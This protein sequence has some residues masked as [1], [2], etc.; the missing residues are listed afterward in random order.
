M[1][2]S[3]VISMCF[4]TACAAGTSDGNPQGS[5][6][7]ELEEKCQILFAFDDAVDD[8]KIINDEAGYFAVKKPDTPVVILDREGT[9]L[10]QTDFVELGEKRGNY[11]PGF[12]GKMWWLLNNMS[13]EIKPVVVSDPVLHEDGEYMLGTIQTEEETVWAIED[14]STGEILLKSDQPLILPQQ[15]GCVIKKGNK[16]GTE[17]D[18]IINL[19][20]GE[21]EYTA[22]KGE[23]I[24]D[25]NAGLWIVQEAEQSQQGEGPVMKI[26]DEEYQPLFE[27]QGFRKMFLNESIICGER[28]DGIAFIMDYTGELLYEAVPGTETVMLTANGNY[29]LV[30]DSNEKNWL[31]EVEVH[32]G[33]IR[34]TMEDMVPSLGCDDR[35]ITIMDPETGMYSYMSTMTM[36]PMMPFSFVSTGESENGYAVAKHEDGTILVLDFYKR[37]GK[38]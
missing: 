18:Q 9:E 20:T 35:I 26:L 34:H 14:T 25:G 12:D 2:F 23:V 5:P 6:Y 27:G 21:T 33:V 3:M 11:L 19:C 16:E 36:K 22:G 38:E 32:G 29:A 10:I 31:L 13:M 4:L 1:L 8:I 30:Q 24:K 28:Q 17:R 15:N 37:N 7:R